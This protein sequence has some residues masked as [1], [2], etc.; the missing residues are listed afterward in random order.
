MIGAKRI[1]LLL[2]MV[3]SGCLY[4]G[5]D[6]SGR[7]FRTFMVPGQPQSRAKWITTP[8]DLND[9]NSFRSDPLRQPENYTVLPLQ[10]VA[11]SRQ[12]GRT[13]P[14]RL[15]R[16]GS[17]E[18]WDSISTTTVFALAAL[19]QVAIGTANSSGNLWVFSCAAC[20]AGALFITAFE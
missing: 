11:F 19:F 9:V 15:R 16:R 2:V 4:S 13:R 8:S 10:H 6:F 20:F 18:R 3:L 17:L 5:S 1:A 12:A 7:S 14:A